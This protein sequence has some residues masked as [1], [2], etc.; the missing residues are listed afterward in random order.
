VIAGRFDRRRC[1]VAGSGALAEAVAGRL[2]AEGAAV[3]ALPATPELASDA[4]AAAA[5]EA[6]A[7]ALG[8]IDVLVTAFSERVEGDFLELDDEAWARSLDANLTAPFLVAR[9]A[10]RA[11]AEEGA[12]VVVHVG[13]DVGARP[14]PRSAAYA[15]A[16][17]GLHLMAAGTA[18]DLAPDGVRVCCVAAAEGA[19]PGPGGVRPGP[20]EVAAA[21]AFCASDAASY[22]LGSTYF[23]DGPLPIRG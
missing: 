13:S 14:G 10:A 6:A 23:L 7:A 18:L 3:H 22:V 5:V 12:G 17:A 2:A 4:G 1:V 9:E 16:K 8:G 21:V 15:A 19:D 11:M 20:A